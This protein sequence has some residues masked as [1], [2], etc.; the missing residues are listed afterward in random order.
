MP[1]R[2]CFCCRSFVADSADKWLW[3]ASIRLLYD[4]NVWALQRMGW[5]RLWSSGEGSKSVSIA[6]SWLGRGS[7]YRD[8]IEGRVGAAIFFSLVDEFILEDIAVGLALQATLYLVEF[9]GSCR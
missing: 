6:L 3:I 8:V 7:V 2:V 4:E 1:Y 9:V 5:R